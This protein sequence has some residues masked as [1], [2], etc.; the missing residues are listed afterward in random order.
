ME[1]FNNNVVLKDLHE[2]LQDSYT[3]ITFNEESC[4]EERAIYTAHVEV[5]DCF[6]DEISIKIISYQSGT[7]HVFMIFDKIEATLENLM[8]INKYNERSAFLRAYISS[9]EDGT[10]LEVHGTNIDCPDTESLCNTI[11]FFINELFD[12]NT[13]PYLQEITKYTYQD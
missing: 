12:D 8:L 7:A 2:L 4:T 3:Y 5:D 9:K 10:Y 13:L 1:L 11:C 6:D